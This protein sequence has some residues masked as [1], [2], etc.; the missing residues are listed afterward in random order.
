MK[1]ICPTCKGEYPI[2][3]NNVDRT[4][5]Y[6]RCPLCGEHQLNPFYEEK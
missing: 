5:K 2:N 1:L 3:E 4:L 6:W